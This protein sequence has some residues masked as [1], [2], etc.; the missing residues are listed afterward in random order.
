MKKIR[1]WKVITAIL[2]VVVLGVGG[3]AT[4]TY[5]KTQNLVNDSYKAA[6]NKQL[7]D[8]NDQIASRKPISVLL[9]GTDTGAFNRTERGRTDTLILATVNPKQQKTTLMSIPRDTRTAIPGFPQLG[10]IKINAAYAYGSTGTAMNTVQK[11][12]DSP[13]D[14]Y[15]LINM[16]GLE[17]L[18]DEV[19][20]VDVK[21]PLSFD[22]AGYQFEKGQTYHMNGKKALEFSRMR[23]EDPQGDYGRQTRQ[24]L[25]ITALIKKIARPSTLADTS[26]LEELSKNVQTNLKFDQLRDLALNYRDGAKKVVSDHMQGQGQMIG[27]QAFE[28]VS[29]QERERVMKVVKD[30]LQ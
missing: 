5:I 3:V 12:V 26:L 6:H 2:V 14:Y 20:G 7:R 24:R 4:Y 22:F 1:I 21:S 8:P 27:G 29:D 16:G 23:H 13:V 11:L 28:V 25:V 9:L 19:D 17:K 18:I 15:V 30:S 10:K